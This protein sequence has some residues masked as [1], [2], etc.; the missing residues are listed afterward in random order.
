MADR[1]SVGAF[2]DRRFGQEVVDYLVDPMLAGIFSSSPSPLSMKHALARVWN[3]E[4]TKGS[5][6]GG[7]LR[8]GMKS[9]PDPRYPGYTRKQLMESFSYDDGMAVLPATLVDKIKQVKQNCRLY[10]KTKV[11]SIERDNHGRWNINGRGKYDAVISTIPTH[12]LSSIKSNV[13]AIQ[14]GFQKLASQV[15][16]APVSVVVLGFQKS[17]IPEHIHGFGTLLPSKE[18]CNILGVNFSS[19]G[20]PNRLSDKSKV[21]WTVYV[22]GNR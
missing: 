4:R 5:V 19:E 14:R 8:G 3:V 20:F 10:T 15:S 2:F 6:I 7:M 9:E 18:G 22:G 11:R 13:R 12:G 17:Q 16:Y 21:F 1:E